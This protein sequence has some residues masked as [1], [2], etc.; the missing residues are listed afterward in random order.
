MSDI[1]WK[2]L[3]LSSLVNI[4]GLQAKHTAVRDAFAAERKAKDAFE[5]ALFLALAKI[6]PAP[7]DH[8][9]VVSYRFGKVSYA[10]AASEAG[11]SK[12]DDDAVT[13]AA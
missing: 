13:L 10:Y 1:T 2:K 3:N 4:P 6:D 5:Q 7:K 8:K 12:K 11:S 9:M